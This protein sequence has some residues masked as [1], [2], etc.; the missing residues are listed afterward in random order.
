MSKIIKKL[1]EENSMCT[2]CMSNF[3]KSVEAF[4]GKCQNC[5]EYY[6][7]ETNDYCERCGEYFDDFYNVSEEGED[8]DEQIRDWIET[9]YY[10]NDG[11]LTP[12]VMANTLDIGWFEAK[13]WIERY[14]ESEAD[15]KMDES[16]SDDDD[17]KYFDG[18]IDD[19]AMKDLDKESWG[20]WADNEIM[21]T[22]DQVKLMQDLGIAD[23][24]LRQMGYLKR[25][26][27]GLTD[28]IEMLAKKF[29]VNLDRDPEQV[30]SKASE[31]DEWSVDTKGADIYQE[32]DSLASAVIN[33]NPSW[34]L[35][36]VRQFLADHPYPKKVIDYVIKSLGESK[37]NEDDYTGVNGKDNIFRF[38]F[39]LQN[40]GVTNMF[41]AGS[42]VKEEFSWLSDSEVR[43]VVS[44]W[45]TNYQEIK[46]RLGES[47]ANEEIIPDWN[48]HADDN[49]SDEEPY[50][51]SDD[52]YELM[53]DQRRDEEEEEKKSNEY[54]D[55][56]EDDEDVAKM[57]QIMGN[58]WS[59]SEARIIQLMYAYSD[60]YDWDDVA[61]VV[62]KELGVDP[63]EALRLYN[64]DQRKLGHDGLELGRNDSWGDSW[65][66]L[67]G[68]SKA[69]EISTFDRLRAWDKREEDKWNSLSKEEQNRINDERDAE[70][71]RQ[72]EEWNN[73]SEEERK[74]YESAGQ[75]FD[76][77]DDDDSE[78]ID[79]NFQ[80]ADSNPEE[81][82]TLS[83]DE[84][85]SKSSE[86]YKT[87]VNNPHIQL[88][89]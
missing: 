81:K 3:L 56:Y 61:I 30:E 9:W 32:A 70:D 36:D 71:L 52:L 89:F 44:E 33:E 72:E 54:T 68:E 40:S 74:S 65:G 82:I 23:K 66:G 88:N 15:F 69:N 67:W 46:D 57:S 53:R 86:S 60:S 79:N 73:M 50:D 21:T 85:L 34:T 28:K 13:D 37:A 59:E 12:E 5:N 39:N 55:E 6:E 2:D 18:L 4:T 80:K 38:L 42:Y 75:D 41:G 19:W 26:G 76:E 16:K 58:G 25:E 78:D 31:W 20:S 22:D 48:Y 87:L 45:M 49:D 63:S 29:G 17:K 77:N 43:E 64:E 51:D 1:Q 62:G 7:N 14:K 47:K 27:E 24:T 8:G 10:D 84:M 35:A 11:E 83:E